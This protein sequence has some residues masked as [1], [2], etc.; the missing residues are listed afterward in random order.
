MKSFFQVVKEAGKMQETERE[1]KRKRVKEEQ[2][3]QG[4]NEKVFFK[5]KE[6]EI[7][8]ERE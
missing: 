6:G 4:K 1:T 3:C 7:K 8:R 2:K 5:K